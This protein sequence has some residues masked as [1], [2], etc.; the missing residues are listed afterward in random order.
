MAKRTQHV[1]PNNVARCFVGMLRAF[2]QAFQ[3]SNLV[4]S[5]C[6]FADDDKGIDKNEKMHV[7]SVQSYRKGIDNRSLNMHTM[8]CDVLVAV[9]VGVAKAP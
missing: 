6:C 1:V 7:Q 9:A 8:I 3:T 4:I 2:G 5:L